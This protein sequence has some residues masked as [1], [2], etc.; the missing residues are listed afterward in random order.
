MPYALPVHSAEFIDKSTAVVRIMNKAA[1]KAK[2]IT[3]KA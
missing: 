2:T 3:T 1:G